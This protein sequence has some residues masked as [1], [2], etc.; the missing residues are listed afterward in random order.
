MDS[1]CETLHNKLSIYI[2]LNTLD[3]A[4][5]FGVDHWMIMGEVSAQQTMQSAVSE[6]VEKLRRLKQGSGYYIDGLAASITKAA[7]EGVVAI[8]DRLSRQLATDVVLP[9]SQGRQL[10]SRL[11]WSD[12]IIKA[13]QYRHKHVQYRG[14]EVT[15]RNFPLP[16]TIE[17]SLIGRRL[18]EVIELP[19]PCALIIREIER[20]YEGV[21]IL[22]LQYV[23]HTLNCGQGTIGDPMPIR[24]CSAVI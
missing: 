24:F 21:L 6:Y 1:H 5:R 22:H 19:K 23:L 18:D 13:S 10:V 17:N 7:P 11:Y 16:D 3:S 9:I 14:T 12:G 8:L 15:L 2:G 20:P 4:L